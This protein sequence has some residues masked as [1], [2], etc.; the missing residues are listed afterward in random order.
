ML[1]AHQNLNGSSGLTLS[2]SGIFCHPW[3]RTCCLENLKLLSPLTIKIWKGLDNT[4]YRQW[5][6]TTFLT[7]TSWIQL[8]TMQLRLLNTACLQDSTASIIHQTSDTTLVSYKLAEKQTISPASTHQSISKFY[9]LDRWG[10]HVQELSIVCRSLCFTTGKVRDNSLTSYAQRNPHN[11]CTEKETS[12]KCQ[13]CNCYLA[14][15][16]A[17]LSNMLNDLRVSSS[18]FDDR[19]SAAVGPAGLTSVLDV[20]VLESSTAPSLSMEDL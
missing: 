14:C 17:S 11:F 6:S 4:L 8:R 3:T 20:I 15:I 5:A 12:E 10:K 7:L 18:N 9:S 1:G 2:L 16:P 19:R 13:S